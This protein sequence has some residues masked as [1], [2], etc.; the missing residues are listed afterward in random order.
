[1]LVCP[2]IKAACCREIGIALID[3]IVKA[4]PICDML[5]QSSKKHS[6]ARIMAHNPLTQFGVVTA[7]LSLIFFTFL[8]VGSCSSHIA[9]EVTGKTVEVPHFAIAVKLSDQAEKR[10]HSIGESVLVIA[11]FDGDALPGQGKYN[12]PNRDVFLGN[13][14]KL[15]DQNSVARFDDSRVPLSDWQR[16]SDKNFFITINTVSARKA[17]K[18]N[19]LECDDPISRRIESFKGKTI[20]VRCKLIAEPPSPAK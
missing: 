10:L 17:D 5:I 18:N 15:V 7:K 6:T 20:E 4:D 2:T 16:L 13:D 1:M 19:L 9:Q 12:P 8:L 14:E 3:R 11:Y